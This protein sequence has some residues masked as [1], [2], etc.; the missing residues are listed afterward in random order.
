MEEKMVSLQE[1]RNWLENQLKSTKKQNTLLRAELEIRIERAGSSSL[2]PLS[3]DADRAQG[4]VPIALPTGDDSLQLS[5]STPFPCIDTMSAKPRSYTSLSSKVRGTE[6]FGSPTGFKGSRPASQCGSRTGNTNINIDMKNNEIKALR[7]SLASERKAVQSLRASIVT[8]EA[9][10]NDLEEFFIKCV[11]DV[12]GDI[13]RRRIA[14]GPGGRPD[15]KQGV[16][17]FQDM[18]QSNISLGDFSAADRKKVLES[19]CANE[20][21]LTFLYNSLFSAKQLE[22][23]H[24]EVV[25]GT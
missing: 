18:I 20:K 6:V 11:D 2:L 21:V 12:K 3:T 16:E 24:P 7:A 14:S 15:T 19:L 22:L 5:T 8:S 23:E 25:R 17:Q 1:D 13:T 10:K 4:Y 9:R